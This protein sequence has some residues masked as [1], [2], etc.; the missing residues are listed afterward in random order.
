MAAEQALKFFPS[1]RVEL[2]F[3]LNGVFN[4]S[5]LEAVMGILLWIVFGIVAGSVA[6][7]LMPGPDRLGMSGTI[8][9]GIAGAVVGGLLGS[10]I[11]GSVATGF[12]L[13]SLLMAIIGSMAVLI[14]YRAYSMRAMA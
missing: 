7:L 1:R 4:S 3:V 2:V 5:F 13:R 8:F 9:V 12:D 14:S 10:M 6:K 11:G